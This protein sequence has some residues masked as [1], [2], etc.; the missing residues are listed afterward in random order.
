MPAIWDEWNE[1]VTMRRPGI[2]K[3]ASHRL[4]WS[5][6]MRADLCRTFIRWLILEASIFPLYMHLLLV[7]TKLSPPTVDL[8]ALMQLRG[9]F[10]TGYQYTAMAW[11]P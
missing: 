7:V 4:A 8:Q 11:T 1:L 6:K 2:R 10:G 5:A 3:I 9:R